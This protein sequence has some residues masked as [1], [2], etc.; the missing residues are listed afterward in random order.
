M[1]KEVFRWLDSHP[2]FYWTVALGATALLLGALIRQAGASPAASRRGHWW[3]DCA[4]FVALFAWRWPFLLVAHQLTPDEAQQ[5][6]GAVTLAHDPVFWRSVDG[7]TAGPLNFYVLLLPSWLGAPVD[8]FFARLIG[9]VCVGTSLA[10]GHR[11]LSAEGRQAAVPATLAATLAFALTTDLEFVHYSTEHLPILLST[12]ALALAWRASRSASALPWLAAGGVAGLL[13]WAKLQAL[14]FLAL[15]GAG[16]ALGFMRDWP[17]HPR[18]AGRTLAAFASGLAAPTCVAL[19]LIGRSGVFT[20]FW[21]SY[22]ARN[23]QYADQ[24]WDLSF[25]L[26]ELWRLTALP[27]TYAVFVLACGALIVAGAMGGWL[28][29]RPAPALFSAAVACAATAV[30]ATLAPRRGFPHYLLFT[31]VP[32]AVLT[33]AALQWA[34]TALSA[35]NQRRVAIA[36]TTAVVLALVG[37]RLFSPPP[38]P[39]GE[40]LQDWRHPYGE[41]AAAVKQHTQPRDS[42]AVWGWETEIYVQT[43][44]PQAIRD[45]HSQRQIEPGPWRDYYRRRYLADLRANRPTIFLDAVGPHSYGYQDRDRFGHENFPELAALVRADY[46]LVAEPRGNRLYLRRDRIGFRNQKT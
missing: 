3:T 37:T 44:L 1:L 8:F 40:L 38:F 20:D 4:I 29:R 36:A 39:I 42:I 2:S 11:I 14:P 26:G 13:P 10:L 28:Q 46:V 31:I 18:A 25:V 24:G 16:A 5:V 9:L 30:I 17:A 27:H 21:F 15:V 41:V 23:F 7:A 12:V 32:F 33:A 45:A 34:T 19:L 43:G 6:A 35:V 22:V